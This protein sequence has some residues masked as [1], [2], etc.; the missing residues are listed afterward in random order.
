MKDQ[1]MTREEVAA[2]LGISPEAV[3]ST[4]RRHG[5][6]EVRGYPRAAVEAIQRTGQGYRS[7]LHR[8]PQHQEEDK[9]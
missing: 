5:V 8:S 2:H 4:L 6:R 9:S 3:R 1:L 7:D